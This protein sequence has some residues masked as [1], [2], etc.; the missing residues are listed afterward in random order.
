MSRRRRL[1]RTARTPRA[2][3]CSRAAARARPSHACSRRSRSIRISLWRWP[4]SPPWRTT[5]AGRTSASRYAKAAL[6]RAD[7]LSPRD[8]YYLEGFYYGNNEDTVERGIAAY[9]KLLE[10]YP[11][12]YAGKHNLANAY[13]AVEQYE[14]SARLGEEL[15][16]TTF[17]LPI[18]LSNLALWTAHLDRY[19]DAMAVVAE[20]DRRFPNTPLTVRQRADVT[21]IFGRLDAAAAALARSA[22]LDP[23]EPT[24]ITDQLTIAI[25][26][27]RWSDADRLFSEEAASND[28]FMR[29]ATE[30]MR[31]NLA[32][33]RGRSDALRRLQGVTKAPRPWGPTFD[34]EL[35]L[36]GARNSL[37]LGQPARALA[38]AQAADRQSAD[39][40]LAPRSSARVY[41]GVALVQLGR[42]AEAKAVAD[43]LAARAAAVDGPRIKSLSALLT[44]LTALDRRDLPAATAALLEA[45]RLLPPRSNY[46]PPP[47]QPEV[48]FAL[49]S[50]YLAAG[51]DAEAE[52]RFALMTTRVERALFPVEYARSVYFLGQI[53][54]RRGDLARA[55]EYHSQ[56]VKLWGDGDID[57]DRVAGARK[58]LNAGRP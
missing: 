19:D 21:M 39:L 13:S 53:A 14:E 33:Y 7:R 20:S 51:H 52:K 57:R 12:H 23:G 31:V 43:T 40:L 47:P 46:G 5:C 2:S 6:D 3:P 54:E 55:R 15:R 30:N 26:Q 37:L 8:R 50:A 10:L 32:L 44:G 22:A 34:A 45:E 42:T 18:S 27:D 48:W 38:Y 58:K 41:E 36:I 24:T 17:V 16:R 25:L 28:P 35:N 9:R 11:D 4:G 49:G 56:F 29:F 1:R